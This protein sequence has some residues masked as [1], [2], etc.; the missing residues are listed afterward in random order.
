MGEEVIVLSPLG[1]FVVDH[2]EEDTW[3]SLA[4]VEEL[5]VT[6]FG[7]PEGV[8]ASSLTRDVLTQ[9]DGLG[10]VQTYTADPP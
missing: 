3:L 10:V 2:L 5:L 9:L 4:D 1:T 8:S 7:A 6:H